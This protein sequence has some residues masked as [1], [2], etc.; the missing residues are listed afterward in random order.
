M[1]MSAAPLRRKD[2]DEGT[3]I[4]GGSKECGHSQKEEADKIGMGILG[5][6][7]IGRCMKEKSP[8]QLCWLTTH[9]GW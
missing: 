7:V 5:R 1:V 6:G 9:E 2:S 3:A 8:N 4:M